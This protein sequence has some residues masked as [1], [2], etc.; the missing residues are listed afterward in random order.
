MI[1]AVIFGSS[2]LFA[3]LVL[4]LL[5]RT[6]IGP[7]DEIDEYCGQVDQDLDAMYS[8]RWSN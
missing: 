6:A 2:V 4:G 8:R 5:F 1:A 3:V 7:L